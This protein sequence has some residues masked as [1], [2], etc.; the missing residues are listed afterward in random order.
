MVQGRWKHLDDGSTLEVETKLRVVGHHAGGIT[1]VDLV[2]RVVGRLVIVL[3][4]DGHTFD[5]VI[6]HVGYLEVVGHW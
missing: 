4:V 2:V 5:R 6:L 3:V 1:L